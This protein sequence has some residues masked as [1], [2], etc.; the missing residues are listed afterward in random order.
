MT[1]H[2]DDLL[3]ACGPSCN[4]IIKDLIDTFKCGTVETGSFRYCGKEIKQDEDFNIHIS[5]SDTTRGVKKIHA[6]PKRHPGDPLTDSDKTQM[7]SV[8]GSL[9]WVCRQCVGKKPG[10]LVNLVITDASHAN[11]SEEMII[12]EMTSVEGYRSQGKISGGRRAK[13]QEIYR[14]ANDQLTDIVRWI[15][16]DVMIADPLTKVMEPV[17]LVQALET[18]VL[19]VEQ[20]LDSVVN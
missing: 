17:K 19:D 16:T 4:W 8:A 15:D 20:P 10:A 14:P 6:E 11:E 1:S 13:T 5:C 9:A 7:K 12:N 3:W 2:V 18:N